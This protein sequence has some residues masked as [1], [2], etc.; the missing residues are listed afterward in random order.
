MIKWN[1]VEVIKEIQYLRIVLEYNFNSR[2][3]SCL[4]RHRTWIKRLASGTGRNSVRT[5]NQSTIKRES[6]MYF[7]VDGVSAYPQRAAVCR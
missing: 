4:S 6:T 5:S 1:K 7:F 3:N 2:N